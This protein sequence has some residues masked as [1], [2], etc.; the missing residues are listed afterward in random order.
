[1]PPGSEV[2]TELFQCGCSVRVVTSTGSQKYTKTMIGQFMFPSQDMGSFSIFRHVGTQPVG[3]KVGA[4][5]HFDDVI[6]SDRRVAEAV[7]ALALSTIGIGTP[8]IPSVCS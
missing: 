2:P 6:E 3:P 7:T 4:M 8:T 5:G 1:M